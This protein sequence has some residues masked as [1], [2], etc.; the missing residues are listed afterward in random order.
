M[1]PKVNK[2]LGGKNTQK[3][4][5]VW[6]VVYI[7]IDLHTVRE[8]GMRIGGITELLLILFKPF[9]LRG[10]TSFLQVAIFP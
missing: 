1:N 6:L 3:F 7:L 5:N 9:Q 8:Q 4:Q 10:K 2:K